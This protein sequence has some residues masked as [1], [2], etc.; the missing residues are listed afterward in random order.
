MSY[1][2]S[3][4][5]A[6]HMDQIKNKYVTNVGAKTLTQ[7]NADSKHT[8]WGVK[9]NDFELLAA[10]LAGVIAD[11][12]HVGIVGYDR[13]CHDTIVRV[14]D[15]LCMLAI[16]VR[17]G[18]TVPIPVNREQAEG[19]VKVGMFYLEQTKGDVYE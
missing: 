11:V 4:Q 10:E 18:L 1:A 7:C 19:M 17:Q 8:Y 2:E 5:N 6:G 9:M 16:N 12:E 14:H 3:L 15:R 13:V